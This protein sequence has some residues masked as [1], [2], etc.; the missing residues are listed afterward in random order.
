[1]ITRWL[2][3]FLCPRCIT[4][5]AAETIGLCDACAERMPSIGKH[6]PTC[7]N[8][9][10]DENLPC[11]ACLKRPPPFTRL[12]VRWQFTEEVR[13]II[14]R[15]KYQ[16]DRSALRILEDEA[17]RLLHTHPVAV[18]AVIA[19]PISIR[20]LIQRGY[21][22]SRYPARAVA[23]KL[24]VPLLPSSVLHKTSRTPQSR[25]PNHAARRRNIR[26]AFAVQGE[27]PP[28]LLL[29]DDVITSGATLREAARTLLAAG[30]QEITVLAIAAAHRPNP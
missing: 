9:V 11:G 15:S 17:C 28:R 5:G 10:A 30:A 23:R 4:C 16:T 29:V 19:L 25:L 22:Q 6:C 13:S 8:G 12:L 26:G 7:A 2:T 18:D 20:R 14:L 1:M 24:G 21:N 27:L 3:R